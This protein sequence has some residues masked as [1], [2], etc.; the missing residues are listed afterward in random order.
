MLRGAAGLPR[1]DQI[2]FLAVGLSEHS[3]TDSRRT[4]FI[5]WARTSEGVMK[6][7][8]ILFSLLLVVLLVVLVALPRAELY[9]L[10]A[11]QGFASAQFELG[12]MYYVGRGV[13]QDYTEAVRW[14]QLAAN[15]GNAYAQHD[16]GVMY[17]AGLGVPKNYSE[18]LKWNRRAAEQGDTRAKNNV[19]WILATAP[20]SKLRNGVEALQLAQQA[21]ANRPEADLFDTLAA[22][23]A[24][25]GQFDNA[26][27]AQQRAIKMLRAGQRQSV[28]EMERRVELYR[29]RQPYRE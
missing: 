4:Y 12:D 5:R 16:L 21:V 2:S 1:R 27:R 23:Y 11:D 3:R 7:L 6:K 29:R 18:A 10:A 19:A 22:A 14:F 9:R 8:A 20:D 24:E 13:R 26:V 28:P 15:Q 17:Y 25:A